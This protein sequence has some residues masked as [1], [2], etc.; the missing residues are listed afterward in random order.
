MITVHNDRPT[1]LFGVRIAPAGAE[2]LP[3]K[4][5]AANARPSVDVHALAAGV[6]RGDRALLAR[7]IS[8]VESTSPRHA[9]SS[10][11]LL[12]Q[13]LPRTGNAVRVGITG[14]PG[15]GKSTFI[16]RLGLLLCARGERVAVLAIDPSS[17]VSG[18]SILGDRTRMPELAGDQRAFIRPSPS[19]GTLGG[20]AR[21]TREAALVCEAA[22]FN[23]IL[24]ETVGVGQSETIVAQMVDC[25]LTLALPGAGDELQGVKRGLLEVVDVIAVNKADGDNVAR[26]ARAAG[27]LASAMTMLRGTHDAVPVIACS[28]AT[29]SGI[30]QVWAAVELCV[31]ARRRS[32]ELDA[33]R[34]RQALRW[35]SQLI[36]EGLRAAL[37]SSP[38]AAAALM[39]AETR[40]R[41]GTLTPAA[42][43]AAVLAAFANDVGRH[44]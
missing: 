8:L 36:D 25:V 13:V 21:R 34:R 9:A 22:G 12:S 43:A 20:V 32:G 19:G 40:V 1:N 23:I 5:N 10:R 27:E 44:A 11:E 35:M 17:T 30:E 41:D 38:A 33:R 15:A 6:L 3:P 26:A 16:E 24:I 42:G 31:D 28:A 29:G 14:V 37:A 4:A 39:D 18:G 7:A 2:T